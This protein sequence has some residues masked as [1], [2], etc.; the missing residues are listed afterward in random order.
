MRTAASATQTG[1]R[2]ISANIMHTSS[3]Q[4]ADTSSARA[5]HAH[6]RTPVNF[7]GRACSPGYAMNMVRMTN[8]G[9]MN[10]T[11]EHRLTEQ[12]LTRQCYLFKGIGA[13]RFTETVS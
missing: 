12:H 6:S 4:K 7:H 11:S 5:Q 9:N 1:A 2:Y 13:L 8:F 3:R 10:A